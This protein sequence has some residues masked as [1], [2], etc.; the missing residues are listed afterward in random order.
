MSRSQSSL[1]IFGAVEDAPEFCPLCG[2]PHEPTPSGWLCRRAFSGECQAKLIVARKR[3]RKSLQSDES[4]AGKPAKA[5]GRQ[6]S[7]PEWLARMQWAGDRSDRC[8]Q[9]FAAAV[10]ELSAVAAASK[11]FGPREKQAATMLEIET[12]DQ[13]GA[14][15]SMRTQFAKQY[16]LLGAPG[17]FGYD[18][19]EGIALQAVYECW[20]ALLKAK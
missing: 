5:K 14:T 12:L 3:N 1:P 15:P 10:A 6:T 20:N 18:R 8:W 9:N 2:S 13:G 11:E 4:A 19:P 16:K 7:R 17:D